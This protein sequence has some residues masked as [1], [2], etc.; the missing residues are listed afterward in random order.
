M[1]CTSDLLHNL[2]PI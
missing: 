1:L 2:A